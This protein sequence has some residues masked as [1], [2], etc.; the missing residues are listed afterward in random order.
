MPR[1][2]PGSH[3]QVFRIRQFRAPSEHEIDMRRVERDAADQALVGVIHSVANQ[4]GGR[5]KL[6]NSFGHDLMNQRPQLQRK[7]LYHRA[8]GRQKLLKLAAHGL[9]PAAERKAIPRILVGRDTV[10]V[11]V[12]KH[13]CASER[14]IV[15]LLKNGR[16]GRCQLA[17]QRVNVITI[18]PKCD[19]PAEMRRFVQV[20]A[21]FADAE[22]NGGRVEE[23]NPGAR[24]CGSSVKPSRSREK[25]RDTDR[26]RTCTLMKSGPRSFATPIPFV[27]ASYVPGWGWRETFVMVNNSAHRLAAA[28][29]APLRRSRPAM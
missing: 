27:I 17:V 2:F 15:G 13:H 20:D 25:A 3:Q 23:Q 7:R 24:K 6:L 12:S 9:P 26:S 8:I 14:T 10:A 19:A 16:T 4:V 5:I 28:R 21:R 29:P 11:R 1:P 22:G 18:D